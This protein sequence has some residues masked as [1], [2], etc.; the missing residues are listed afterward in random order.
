MSW[1]RAGVAFL[2]L[3]V[4]VGASAGQTAETTPL[5]QNE[6]ASLVNAK[7]PTGDII[8]QIKARGINFQVTPELEASLQQVEGGAALLEALRAPATLEVAVNVAGAEVE[9]DGKSRGTA[10]PDKPVVV[11]DLAPGSHLIRV[12]AE[13][14]VP[15]R[16]SVFLKP[17]ESHR[18]EIALGSAVTTE[19]GLLGTEVNVKA[20]TT[21]DALVV[22]VEG[23]SDP[24]E[25][26]ARLEEMAQSYADSPLSLLACEMLQAAYMRGEQYDKALEAGQ[27]VLQRDPENFQAYLGIAQAH[28]HRGEIDPAFE[29]AEHAH[30]ILKGAE[31]KPAPATMPPGGKDTL[32]EQA[33]QR[34][35]NLAYEFYVTTARASDPAQRSTFLE[36]FLQLYPDSPYGSYALVTLAYAYQQQGNTDKALEWGEKALSDDPDTPAMAVLVSDIL[37]DR[38]QNLERAWELASRLVER[39][40]TDPSAVRPDGLGDEQWERLRRLWEGTAQSAL[41]QVLLHQE[42]AQRP[43]G[44]TKTRQAIEHFQKASP[45]LKA[46]K[47][48]Y[49]RNLFR[50]GFAQAKVGDLAEAKAALTEVISLGT[51]YTA[52]AQETLNRVEEGLQRRN[53]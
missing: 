35:Q 52:P 43:A 46:E 10:T 48:L 50:L 16:Q 37:S 9:V 27:A 21:E 25:R 51:P 44:M 49:A 24:T 36:H 38:G 2:G 53:Q 28:L 17:D 23:L 34:L 15:E 30:T 6:F 1:R 7:V 5:T 14:Y 11:S 33:R 8:A 20:G 42:T 19:P 26:I 40:E 47:Q 31:A 4:L 32:M 45:L 39:L 13:Q 22:G 18:V 3:L 12:E 29:A 41:G